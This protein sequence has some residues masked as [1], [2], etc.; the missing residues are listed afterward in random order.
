MIFLW[1]ILMGHLSYEKRYSWKEPNTA[2]FL[3]TV[4]TEMIPCVLITLHIFTKEI[5]T[6]NRGPNAVSVVRLKGCWSTIYM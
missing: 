3:H 6:A 4:Q 1:C 2:W 5:P